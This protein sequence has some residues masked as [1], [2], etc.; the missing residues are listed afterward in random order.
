VVSIPISALA[1]DN[2]VTRTDRMPWYA[3]PSLLQHLEA[4]P[5]RRAAVD[6]AVRIPVQ[7]VIR[8]DAS[9]RG[10]AGQIASGSI[11]PGDAVMA[12]PSKK[13]SR[14][15]SI[16]TREGQEGEAF[17]PMSVTLTLED[18]IDLSRGDMLVSPQRLPHVSPH[19]EAMVVWFDEQPLTLGRTYLIK[20]AVR[21]AR[22]KPVEINYRV[23]MGNLQQ[24]PTHELRLNDIGAVRFE[25]ANPIFFDL[26]ATNRTTGSFILIDPLTNATVGAAMIHEALAGGETLGPGL[27]NAPVGKLERHRRH[28]HRPA[29]VLAGDRAELAK[30]LERTLFRQGFEVVRVSSGELSAEQLS[31]VLR[32]AQTAG[33]IV[34]Y[35]G[36]AAAGMAA[37]AGTNCLDLAGMSLP[38]DDEAA[39][40]AILPALQSLRDLSKN[41]AEA[42]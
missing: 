18:E 14:I 36:N 7:Y 42:N 41:D 29:L 30:R 31:A 10:F 34:I 19:F 40:E 12:L 23:E 38:E 11:R 32:F 39:V 13:K 15:R 5:I 25:A 16:V 2:V 17:A 27:P 35:S 37:S 6:E 3:G 22:V 21:N 20:H 24:E 1:G 4:A 8:P 28:G 33:L 26:Y 9:F